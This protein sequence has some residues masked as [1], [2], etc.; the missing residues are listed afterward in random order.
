P[1]SDPT[2][3]PYHLIDQLAEEFARRYR[4]G[5][6]PSLTEYIDRYP[7]LAE[8]IRE[9]FPALA[10]LEQAE[11]ELH[12]DS[13]DRG[14]QPALAQLGD[15]RIV[16]E[17]G[18]GGMGIVYEADQLS[19]GRRVALKVLPHQAAHDRRATERFRREAR[20]VARLHHTNVV[21]IFEVG[22]EGDVSYY[23]MQFIR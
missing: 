9:L 15:F 17:V 13:P 10:R 2:P 8:E 7:E 14:P 12:R 6:R 11:E 18:R 1:A 21:P 5:Q 3:E 16:R 20:A 4:L 23:A 22:Q 19:L